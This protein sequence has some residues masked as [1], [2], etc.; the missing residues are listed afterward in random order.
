M[1]QYTILVAG[2]FAGK[3]TIPYSASIDKFWTIRFLIG[4]DELYELGIGYRYDRTHI[5]VTTFWLTLP[6]ID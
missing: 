5:F 6:R 1:I 4:K 3:N 2:Y